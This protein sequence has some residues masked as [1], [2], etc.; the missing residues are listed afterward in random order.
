MSRDHAFPASL[1]RVHPVH[2]VPVAAIAASAAPQLA[3]G[4]LY[5]GNST[6]F[7]GLISGVL[8][9]YMLSYAVAVG[10]H[11]A[12]RL[13]GRRLAYGPWALGRWSG[14]LNAVA[15]VWTVGVGV[16]LCFPLYRPVTAVNMNYASVIVGVGGVLGVVW[17]FAY[18]R[19]R[20]VGPVVEIVD[21]ADVVVI[22]APMSR[23]TS[24]NDAV[25]QDG[26]DKKFPI[27]A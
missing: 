23:Q 3:V 7:Y 24:S 6:A 9:L 1:A 20:F 21:D 15:L 14:V 2:D 22:E 4:A 26:R 27:E 19:G 8:A 11:I 17:Y 12:A 18:M 13:R 25:V 10:L 5:I 16:F